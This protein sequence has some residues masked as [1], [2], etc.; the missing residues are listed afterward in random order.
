MRDGDSAT[1]F[2]ESETTS[3]D[4]LLYEI[5]GHAPTARPAVTYEYAIGGCP[6]LSCMMLLQILLPVGQLLIEGEWCS[7]LADSWLSRSVQASL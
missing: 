3:F 7:T 6:V 2:H 4:F 1:E 5:F